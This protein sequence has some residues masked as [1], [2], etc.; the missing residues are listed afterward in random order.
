MSEF[1]NFAEQL[2]S[3]TPS[4]KFIQSDSGWFSHL[5]FFSFGR[6]FA[7]SQKNKKS[8]KA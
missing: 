7:E 5:E 8:Y 6:G 4:S 3:M 1:G 2:Y